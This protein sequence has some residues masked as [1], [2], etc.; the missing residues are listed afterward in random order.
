MMLRK[1]PRTSSRRGQSTVELA[2]IAPILVLLLVAVADGGRMFFAY[3]QVIGAARAGAQY[4]AQSLTTSNDFNGMKS[5][6][7]SAAPNLSGLSA[8]ATN[9]CCC[10]SGTACTTFG[11]TATTTT[12]KQSCGVK[13]TCNA[14]RK[15][16]VVTATA[17]FS[18]LLNYPGLPSTMNFSRQCQLRSK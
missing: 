9:L 17:T 8:T 4:G 5:H 2:L 18:T 1:A 10:P 11:S 3:F 12:Y 15:Y 14:W 6:A 16:E 13:P 7:V